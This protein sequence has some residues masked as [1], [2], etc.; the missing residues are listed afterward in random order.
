M[1]KQMKDLLDAIEI[2]KIAQMSDHE[3]HTEVDSID[4]VI[5]MLS[6]LRSKIQRLPSMIEELNGKNIDFSNSPGDEIMI[7][8][9][10]ITDSSVGFLDRII[11]SI[12]SIKAK[13]QQK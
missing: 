8:L 1:N 5:F 12:K 9:N 2:E 11:D 6:V 7:D 13:E 10:G 3:L 4:G